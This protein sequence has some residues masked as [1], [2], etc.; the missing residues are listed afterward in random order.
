MDLCRSQSARGCLPLFMFPR[1]TWSPAQRWMTY[2]SLWMNRLF[3]TLPG[4]LRAEE[5]ERRPGGL[6]AWPPLSGALLAAAR[7]GF[8]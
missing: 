5:A 2:S 7:V 1:G 8:G 4:E 3:P 6:E